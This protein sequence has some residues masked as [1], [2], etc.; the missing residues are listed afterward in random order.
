VSALKSNKLFEAKLNVSTEVNSVDGV[1]LTIPKV[2]GSIS[3]GL[4][5]N[6]GKF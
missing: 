1:R 4:A 3:N 5:V 2:V 6:D